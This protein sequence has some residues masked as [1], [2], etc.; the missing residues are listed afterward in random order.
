L[1][2][3]LPLLLLLLLLPL[4]LVPESVTRIGPVP[5]SESHCR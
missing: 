4:P 5:V 1:E 3:A 2:Q